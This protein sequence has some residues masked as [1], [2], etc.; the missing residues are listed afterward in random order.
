MAKKTTVRNENKAHSSTQRHA[1]KSGREG[2]SENVGGRPQKTQENKLNRDI[3]KMARG[4]KSK[5]GCSP[6]LFMLLLPLMAAGA[7]FF[8]RS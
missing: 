8:L 7:Y 6:K 1:R 3:K 4:N 2:R 5:N